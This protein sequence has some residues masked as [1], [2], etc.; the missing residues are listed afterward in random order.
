MRCGGAKAVGLSQDASNRICRRHALLAAPT[1]GN[2]LACDQNDHVVARPAYG[3]GIFA[4]PDDASVLADF[5]NLPVMRAAKLFYAGRQLSFNEFSV[6]LK[7]NAKHRLSHQISGRI[8]ELRC[9]K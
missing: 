4:N 1:F 9:A 6:L 5:S 8:A 2:V 7:K 3:L